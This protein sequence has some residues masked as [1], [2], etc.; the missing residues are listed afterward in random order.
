[1]LL[2][3]ESGRALL[4]DFGIARTAEGSSL[5]ASGMVVGTP[6][7]MSPE[8]VT[9]ERVD[10]RSDLYALGCV[11]YQMLAGEPPF[12]GSTAEA[13]LYRRVAEA[14]V[15][16]QAKRPDVPPELAEVVSRC[17]QPDPAKR[18][19]SA[20]DIVRALG[21]TAPV[22]G[23]RSLERL[24]RRRLR[25]WVPIT[26]GGVGVAAV[27]VGA[28]LSVRG[29][30][31]PEPPTPPLPEAMVLV[32]GGTYTI[33]VDEDH[34]WSRPAHT[35]RVDS[36][37]I[38]RTE[39][40]VGDYARFIAMQG[41]PAPWS[42]MPDGTLPVSG[43][44]WNEAQQYCAWRV[45]G[46]RLPTEAEWEVAA[47]GA[48]GRRYPWGDAWQ[49]NAA[50]A[51]MGAASRPAPVGSR[52]AGATPSGVYDLVGNVWEW[53]ATTTGAHPGG[54]LP[55]RSEGT[56]VIRGGAHN[57]PRALA[58]AVYRGYMPPAARREELA[59]T[60]FRCATSVGRPGA[61]APG[62]P[63]GAPD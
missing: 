36:F 52:P 27:A 29:G 26:L 53:T 4:T 23:T 1:M 30:D 9:G 16:V 19:A 2:E 45:S 3:R 11:A 57:T 10:H 18:P 33:G 32:A 42:R 39:V 47:R 7:Y 55:P 51:A 63:A 62:S 54:G 35:I 22:S 44:T 37:A 5:T 20:S 28:L 41:M 49:L 46:G 8:Q 40:T 59:A 43:V 21:G 12:T 6:T 31:R 34:E 15:P 38:D 14:P 60:G 61:P 13:I 56:Y 17:L 25:G 24:V 48:T 58:D 50:V